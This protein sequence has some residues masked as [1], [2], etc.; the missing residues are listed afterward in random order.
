MN[1]PEA[2]LEARVRRAYE[3]GRLRSAALRALPIVPLVA[4]A[5]AGCS[6]PREV[7]ACGAVL[8]VAVTGFLWR[9]QE[10]GAGV[11]PGIGAGLLPLLLPVFSRACGHPCSAASC[12]VM[13]IMCA[14]GGLAG[15]VLLGVLAPAPHAGRRVSFVV[16]CVVAALTGAVGC[17]LYGLV[18][19]VVMG[20]GLVVG[21]TPLVATRRA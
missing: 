21:A 16:A 2:R 6:S 1:A 4:L 7:I 19:L 9:G 5:T 12:Y 14:V 20:A 17:L 11:G 13:P 8:L 18:G 10:F 15:G 3:R